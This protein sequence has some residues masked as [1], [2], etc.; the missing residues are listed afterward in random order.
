MPIQ[1]TF[2]LKAKQ[3]GPWLKE[4]WAFGYILYIMVF[5]V[6]QA[7]SSI[8]QIYFKSEIV[9]AFWKAETAYIA[10]T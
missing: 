3:F 10:Y 7:Y 4:I 2:K 8:V 6:M 5:V 9:L 1:E